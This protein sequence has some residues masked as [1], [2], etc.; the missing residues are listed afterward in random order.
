MGVGERLFFHCLRLSY[1]FPT[2]AA[3]EVFAEAADLVPPMFCLPRTK[4]ALSKVDRQLEWLHWASAD[5]VDVRCRGSKGDQMRNG[6][7]VTRQK[8]GGVGARSGTQGTSS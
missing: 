8:Q 7:I 3:E 5:K 6:A 4:V 2:R 1:F